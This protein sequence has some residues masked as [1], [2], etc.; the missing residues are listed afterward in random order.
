MQQGS[1]RPLRLIPTN[2]LPDEPA[3]VILPHLVRFRSQCQAIT[4]KHEVPDT[5][6]ATLSWNQRLLDVVRHL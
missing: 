4:I 6:F 1:F 2:T 5:I 3:L